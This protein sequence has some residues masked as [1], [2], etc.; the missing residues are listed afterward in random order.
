MGAG[1]PQLRRTCGQAVLA[2][3]VGSL[4]AFPQPG[5]PTG[6]PT[7]RPAER[8]LFAASPV[9]ASACTVSPG[10]ARGPLAGRG[11]CTHHGRPG[12]SERPPGAGCL[13]PVRISAS[14]GQR[15]VKQVHTGHA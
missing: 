4:R 10:A 5:R 8:L 14:R 15:Q 2:S 9:P 13:G 6:L 3:E 1:S 12:G 7:P 11:V